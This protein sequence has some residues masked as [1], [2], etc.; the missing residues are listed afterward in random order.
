MRNLIFVVVILLLGT[1]SYAADQRGDRPRSSVGESEAISL[2]KLSLEEVAALVPTASGMRYIGCPSCDGGSQE[3]GVLRW[4][5]GMGDSVRCRFCKMTFPN[6]QYPN[7]KEIRITAPD[8]TIQIYRYHESATKRQYFY[9]AHAWF[10]QMMW[11]RSSAV[12]LAE[13][14]RKTGDLNSADRAAVILARFAQVVP[15]Y[16]IRFDFPFRPKQ[17][18]PANQRFPYDGIAPYR[19]AKFDSWAF[20]DIPDDLSGA[21]KILKD[22]KYDYSRLGNRFGPDPSALIEKDLLRLLVENTAAIKDIYHNMSPGMYRD[23]FRVGRD[24]GEPKY[25]HDA[26]DRFRKL[27]DDKFFSDGWWA[28]GATSYHRQTIESLGRF[29]EAVNG[30]TDPPEWTKDRFDNLDLLR[31]APMYRRA[32]QVWAESVLPNGH[33]I[34][35][36]DTWASTVIKPTTS[37]ASRLWPNMGQALLGAGSGDNQVCLGLNWSGN[38][39]H[40]HMDN[41]SIFLY[42]FGHEMLPDIGYSHTRWHNWTINSASHNMVVVDERSQAD[43][44]T[45]ETTTQGNLRWYDASDAHVR[46]IDLDASPAYPGVETY[47]RR[48]ALVHAAEGFDYV[49]DRF[50]VEGGKIHDLFLHGSADEPGRLETSVPIETAVA[51]LVPEWGGC[52]NYIG[53]GDKDLVGTKFHAYDLL[54]EVYSSPA[55]GM[56]NATWRYDSQGLRSHMITPKGS[57]LYRYTSPMIRP[58]GNLDANLSKYMTPGIMARHQGGKSVFAT[59]H[60]PFRGNTWIESVK[61]DPDKLTV[62]YTLSGGKAV[63]D[64]IK[65]GDDA[66]SIES[67]AGWS[68][69]TGKPVGGKVAG[70]ESRDGKSVLKLDKAAPDAAAVRINFGPTRSFVFPVEKVDGDMLQLASDAGIVMDSPE[71]AHFK[72]FP[73]DKL[74]GEITWTI[75]RRK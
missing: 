33:M 30:Y 73:H 36:N 49:I 12:R 17:F 48:L 35:I 55:A 60:E 40:A 38:Y 14:Y 41:G 26:V 67:S 15:G 52:G 43:K 5:P 39:G 8:G 37:S 58:A 19:A 51:S 61:G 74:S 31:D 3:N 72:T 34:P 71:S 28:E 75:Y 53:E 4:Q 46:M 44:G 2:E 10:E 57:T 56:W 21:W 25:V 7:N 62:A 6:P 68:Y 42:A 65:I 50:D 70:I 59:I 27:L 29:A 18:F 69:E 64:T 63:K 22:A 13:H 24:L 47:R 45:S 66:I 54:K 32:R 23:M 20:M 11:M 1:A 9:E 16:A